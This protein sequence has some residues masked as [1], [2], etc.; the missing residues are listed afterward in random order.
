MTLVECYWVA[1][2]L[3]DV[4]VADGLTPVVKTG[5]AKLIV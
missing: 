2:R 1:E 4:L 5:G 3:Y